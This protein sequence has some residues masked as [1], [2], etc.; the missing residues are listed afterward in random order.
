MNQANDQ[1]CASMPNSYAILPVTSTDLEWRRT[2][3][4]VDLTLPL[5]D[6]LIYAF[7]FFP[8][9]VVTAKL[10][11]GADTVIVPV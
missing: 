2:A 4:E 8:A 7:S 3:P 6:S 5:C 1:C 11:A 9:A 10:V